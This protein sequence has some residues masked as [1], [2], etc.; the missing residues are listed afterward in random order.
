LLGFADAVFL[1][2]GDG[3]KSVNQFF[4]TGSTIAGLP[5]VSSHAADS[6]SL[7]YH[8]DKVTCLSPRQI[9]CNFAGFAEWMLMIV[10]SLCTGF[11]LIVE[12]HWKYLNFFVL[13]SRPWK[14]LNFIPQVL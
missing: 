9:D 12:S 4:F 5:Y 13:N 1:Q 6:V 14:Y 2:S 10:K 8:S 11:P 7:L 3:V